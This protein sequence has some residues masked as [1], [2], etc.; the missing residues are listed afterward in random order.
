MPMEWVIEANSLSADLLR[1]D[2]TIYIDISP[3]I[4]MQRLSTGRSSTELY[5]TIENLRIVRDKYYEAF[6]LLKFKENI[7]ITDGNRSTD[8][9]AADIWNKIQ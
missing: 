5:E 8:V 9:I 7:F 6:E 1:P 4:S 2:L 3:E